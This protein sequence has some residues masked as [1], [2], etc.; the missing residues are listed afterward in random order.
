[1]KVA[2][3]SNR[4]HLTK[5]N[6]LRQT[7]L[8][9]CWSLSSFS[10]LYRGSFNMDHSNEPLVHPV[11]EA[12][13]ALNLQLLSF[14]LS[15]STSP[16]ALKG[17]GWT[18]SPTSQIQG[19]CWQC[20]QEPSPQVYCW[21][22]KPESLWSCSAIGNKAPHNLLAKT[23]LI[24]DLIKHWLQTITDW[25]LQNGAPAAW[26]LHSSRLRPQSVICP[27]PMT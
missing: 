6:D 27:Q 24:Y 26:I 18:N 12:E 4:F 23:V 2:H 10:G 13:V 11:Q 16:R 7:L 22:M 9:T 25:N 8:D 3:E 20:G 17:L 19:S 5:L 1:M 21:R 15:S 14:S